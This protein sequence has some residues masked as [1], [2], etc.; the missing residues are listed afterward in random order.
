MH[1]AYYTREG[2]YAATAKLLRNKDRPTAIFVSSDLEAM[3][4][5]RAIHDFHLRIPE[6]IA[7]ISFDG[8]ADAHYT[9]PAL[10]TM[11]H[12]FA[13]LAQ[14]AVAAALTPLSVPDVQLVKAELIIG[15]SCGC[16]PTAKIHQN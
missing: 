7:V 4:A 5:L 2:G 15:N 12:N 8:T 13:Q 16:T 3:G 6:D 11:Q 14:M 9:V 10:T 1:R